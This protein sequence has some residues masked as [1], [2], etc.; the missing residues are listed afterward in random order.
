MIV[1]P[2]TINLIYAFQYILCGSNMRACS[3]CF[4]YDNSQTKLSYLMQ[5]H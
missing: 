4:F 2:Q 3:D 1:N 5:L